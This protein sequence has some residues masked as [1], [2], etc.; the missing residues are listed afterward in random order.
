MT[1]KEVNGDRMRAV[2]VKRGKT[3]LLGATREGKKK[4]SSKPLNEE[5]VQIGIIEGPPARDGGG[6]AHR[7]RHFLSSSTKK[8][9]LGGNPAE[10][11]HQSE[12]KE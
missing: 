5:Y 2:G 3:L 9:E 7:M 4:T 12:K 1:S 8:P 10:A 11:L 6:S